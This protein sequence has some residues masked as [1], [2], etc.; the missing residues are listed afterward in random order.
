MIRI[1]FRAW[2]TASHILDNESQCVLQTGEGA[3]IAALN[4]A[5]NPSPC[6]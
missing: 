1:R 6:P 2:F 4:V 3:L 5:D